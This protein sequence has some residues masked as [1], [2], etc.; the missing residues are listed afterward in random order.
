MP[1]SQ[2][3]GLT[4]HECLRLLEKHRF[5]WMVPTLVCAFLAT[6]YAL[7]MPRY[8]QANQ[9]LVVRPEAT[10]SDSGELGKF[11]DLHEMKTFQETILELV[12]S[13][14]V[15]TATLSN[16]ADHDSTTNIEI[17]DRDVET[18]RRRLNMSPPGGAE[19]GKTEVFYLS[20][21]D[22]DRSRAKQLVAELSQQLDIRLRTLRNQQAESLI[23]ELEQQVALAEQAQSSVT[24]YLEEFEAGVGADL[25]ELRM[26]HSGSSGQSDLRQQAVQLEREIRQATNEVHQAEQLVV[27]LKLA[28]ANPDQLVAMPSSLLQSQPTLRHLK[29]GLHDAQLRA[30]R[31]AGT[32]TTAHPHV[33]A[34]NDAVAQ[35]RHD[36]HNE[37]TVA[38]H[39]VNVELE[40][41][42]QRYVDLKNQSRELNRRLA[43]LAQQRAEY[44]NRVAAV[45]NSRKVLD[46]ARQQLTEARSQ[47]FAALSASLVTPLDAPDAG[48]GP[49]G[50]RRAVVPLLGGLGGLIL[51]LG[52]IFL[53]VTPMQSVTPE[54]DDT[55]QRQSTW[56][57]AFATLPERCCTS[58]EA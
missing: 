16:M 9:A 13:R 3:A 53:T 55:Q 46:Q 22:T 19:F 27:V 49:V 39:G 30:A 11:A 51:G 56:S 40:L 26:L 35:I 38:I 58:A 10:A 31:V 4:P 2:P 23:A 43:A 41:S 25:G 54:F 34:A 33:Q 7:M 50:L 5:R 17:S 48:T 52:W 14:Q 32:R 18:F 44:S 24:Q 47:Q 15:I 1:T 20:V 8:W 42:R 6:T 36:L 21:Q 45:E 12:K 29:D 37:L 28:Q 57:E